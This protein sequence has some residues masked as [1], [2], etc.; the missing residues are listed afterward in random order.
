MYAVSFSQTI[1]DRFRA[2]DD[3]LHGKIEEAVT[4]DLADIRREM[5]GE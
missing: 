2:N 4:D 1:L 3:E 5:E